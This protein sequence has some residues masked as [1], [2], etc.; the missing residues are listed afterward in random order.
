MRREDTPP[1]ELA[2]RSRKDRE[3]PRRSR[4]TAGL[5][6]AGLLLASGTAA[7]TSPAHAATAPTTDVTLATPF[8]H[9]GFVGNSSISA[10]GS[11][12]AYPC[13]AD[14][15]DPGANQAALCVGTLPATTVTKHIVPA[16][17]LGVTIA[18][19]HIRHEVY[20]TSADGSS[21][22]VGQ[23]FRVGSNY[24]GALGLLDPGEG[25]YTSIL[26]VETE[27]YFIP[28]VSAYLSNDGETVVFHTDTSLI[29]EDTDESYDLYVYD[30][31]AASYRLLGD[32]PDAY[33]G[34]TSPTMPMHP[35]DSG[36][37]AATRSLDRVQVARWYH[38][39]T[40]ERVVLDV[41]TGST[42]DIGCG[43]GTLAAFSQ[44]DEVLCTGI[45]TEGATTFETLA[46][47]ASGSVDLDEIDAAPYS[48]GGDSCSGGL[49][50]VAF[51]DDASWVL[52]TKG[53]EIVR[54]DVATKAKSAWT[55]LGTPVD[56]SSADGRTWL[57][58][59]LAHD[60]IVRIAASDTPPPPPP[61]FSDVPGTHPFA[62]NIAWLATSGITTGYADGTFR[63]DAVV[64]RGSM[65]AFLYRYAGNPV[66]NAPAVSPFKD[67]PTSHA[68]Y[69]EITW[70]AS[71]GV[72]SG[73]ADG[74]YKPDAPVTRQSMAAFLWRFAGFPEP[75][76][77]NPTFTDVGAG[78][79]FAAPIRHLA[80]AAITTGYA[81]G[82]FKPGAPVTRQ[83]MA[84]FI[85]RADQKLWH[86]NP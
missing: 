76:G 5:L 8:A 84:A 78:H 55:M 9:N 67:V 61:S 58:A 52:Y 39:S 15:A 43:T 14:G 57:E 47:G 54:Y 59:T 50:V 6:A 11:T 1:L 41:A 72:T 34:L 64:N 16:L 63:P 17:P 68:F 23:L 80:V 62:A 30:V 74:T 28:Q 37:T 73:Y 77:P 48:C 86:W 40:S 75:E 26:T 10:D 24:Y 21:V 18:N 44:G 45:R 79:T 12:V 32:V 4:R 13:L 7:V 82:T 85:Q 69:K 33:V 71:T 29:P 19:S 53:T 36:N 65:A 56:T 20:G 27:N 81:D 35:Y 3:R 22:L 46:V 38:D 70:L 25:T 51:A 42:L 2:R 49:R 31:Q 66:F 60:A 83:S